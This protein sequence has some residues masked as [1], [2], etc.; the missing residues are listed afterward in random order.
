L[1]VLCVVVLFLVGGV[2]GLWL[3]L[4]VGGCVLVCVGVGLCVWGWCRGGGG[5]REHTFTCVGGVCVCV[6]LYE[7]ALCSVNRCAC[8]YS[9]HSLRNEDM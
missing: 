7:R 3:W 8:M 1:V 5:V 6:R 4:W 2:G 9:A